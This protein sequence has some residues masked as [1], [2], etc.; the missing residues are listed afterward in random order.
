MHYITE[1]KYNKLHA[2]YRGI[3][4]DYQELSPELKGK[5]TMMLP[6]NGGLAIEGANL[7][8]VSDFER[9]LILNDEQIAKFDYLDDWHRPI[10]KIVHNEKQL[11]VCFVDT[12]MYSLTNYGEPNYQLKH[13]YQIN[14]L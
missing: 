9:D 7:T 1:K 5:R 2:D 3:F 6:D 11:R 4:Q 13:D 10:F 14:L 8:I 12:A